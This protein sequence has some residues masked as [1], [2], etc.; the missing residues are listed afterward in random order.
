VVRVGN[1]VDFSRDDRPATTEYW[2]FSP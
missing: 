2:V 1:E